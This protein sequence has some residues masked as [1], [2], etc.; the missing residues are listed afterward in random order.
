MKSLL[1]NS[2]DSRRLRHRIT[3]V[4]GHT[5]SAA[6]RQLQ[7]DGITVITVPETD[8]PYANDHKF[9]KRFFLSL[10]KLRVF[11]MTNYSR[12][13]F[14]DADSLVLGDL[15]LLF[16]CANFC[17]AFINPCH[18]NTGLMLLTPNETLYSDMIRTLPSLPSYDGG[19]QGFLNSYFP[20]MLSAPFFHPLTPE[21]NTTHTSPFARL[22]FSWHVDHSAFLPTFAFEFEKTSRCASRRVIEWLGPPVAKPWVWWNYSVLHLSWLWHSYRVQLAD[23]YP[24]TGAHRFRGIALIAL[25]LIF[26]YYASACFRIG[27]RPSTF[28]LHHL[29]RFCPF[30]K[31]DNYMSCYYPILA[32]VLLWAICFSLSVY[33]VPTFLPPFFATAVFFT[34]RV[35]LNLSTLLVVGPV[36]CFGQ[37]PKAPVR[38]LYVK[39]DARLRSAFTKMVAWSVLDATYM[40]VCT[41][42]AW[43]IKFPH[44]LAKATFIFAVLVAQLGLAVL[45][46]AHIALTWLRMMNNFETIAST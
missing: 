20:N 7:Q 24:P 11:N 30:C 5:S 2:P 27:R 35:A 44:M 25:S 8:S 1:L 43:S 13:V 42:I 17:A 29:P 16:R 33:L 15:S 10:T 28:L 6:K 19:D 14:I 39:T 3:I 23:P 22:P 12:I 37:S 41:A 26:I 21:R 4:T 31:V 9:Q 45:M 18:F 34:L 36:F 38:A 46:I 32:G 40:V